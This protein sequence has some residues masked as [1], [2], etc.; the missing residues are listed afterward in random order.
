MKDTR[1]L[2]DGEFEI[3]PNARLFRARGNSL[4][5]VPAKWTG[6]RICV[7]ES[8]QMC[9]DHRLMEVFPIYHEGKSTAFFILAR[10]LRL[11]RGQTS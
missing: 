9:Y 11:I 10:E 1:S 8:V 7:G 6:A 5:R 3:A 4:E 2:P